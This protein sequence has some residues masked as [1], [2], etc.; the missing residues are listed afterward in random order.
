MQLDQEGD[1]QHPCAAGEDPITL[2]S[3]PTKDPGSLE[4]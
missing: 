3:F 2:K 4:K 1:I